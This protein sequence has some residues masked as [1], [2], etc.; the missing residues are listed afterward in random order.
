[1]KGMYTSVRALPVTSVQ[2]TG[3]NWHRQRREEQRVCLRRGDKKTFG[4]SHLDSES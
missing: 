1:M 2:Q 3:P 4:S